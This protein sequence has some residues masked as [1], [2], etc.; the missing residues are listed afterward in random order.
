MAALVFWSSAGFRYAA[1]VDVPD[2]VGV[3]PD[4]LSEE[5]GFASP[6]GEAFD[7]EELSVFAAVSFAGS[8]L[9]EEL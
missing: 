9:E 4:E 2:E 5:A 6:L 8:L 7:S 3:E 1:A